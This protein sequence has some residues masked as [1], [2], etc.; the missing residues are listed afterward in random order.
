MDRWRNQCQLEVPGPG[1][2]GRCKRT[3]ICLPGQQRVQDSEPT[4]CTAPPPALPQLP[5]AAKL[6]VRELLRP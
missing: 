2:S 3:T 6:S 1:G 5:A 4:R